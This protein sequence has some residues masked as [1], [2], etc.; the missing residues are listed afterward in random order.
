MSMGNLLGNFDFIWRMTGGRASCPVSVIAKLAMV[1][2]SAGLAF[3][4]SEIVS[5]RSTE[6]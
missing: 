4:S 6:K 5:S 1:E 2:W 3:R